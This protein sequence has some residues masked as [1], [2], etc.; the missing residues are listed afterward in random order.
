MKKRLVLIGLLLV[1]ML[2]ILLIGLMNSTT[3]SRW[4]VQAVLPAQV[5]VE[6][7]DGRLLDR[8]TLLGLRYESDSETIAVRRFVFA[9]QPSQLFLGVIKIIDVTANDINISL[10]ETTQAEPSTFDPNA[11][12]PVPMP[13][14]LENLLVTNLT[15]QQD[16]QLQHLEKLHLSAFTEQD[17]LNI[18]ALSVNAKPVELTAQGQMVLGK[19]FPLNLTADWQVATEENGLWQAKTTI[20]GDLKQLT[21]D[22]RL[23]SP[24]KLALNGRLE[25]LQGE[26][27]ISLQGDWQKL[28]WPPT[29]GAPQVSSNQGHI[30]LN[31]LLSDYRISLD[32][33]LIQPYLPKA[34][35]T[36]NGTGSLDAL[37]IETLE[38]ESTA[39]IFQIDGNVSWKDATTFDLKASGQNFNPAI[40]MPELPGSLT[41][42]ARL[43]G[44]LA[45]E[46]LRLDADIKQLAGKLRGY[47][48][49]AN[50]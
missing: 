1:L 21:F 43:K 41:F 38:L 4:L 39:G 34:R 46:T 37:T 19:G 44:Q 23:A 3:V 15:I 29:G 10:T 33:D 31:G 48:V 35:L 32:G 2:P 40:L 7:I 11:D 36:F 47:P 6:S 25:D 13:I 26:L 5:S 28:N 42:N 17:R 16:G 12:L 24:F 27:K 49:S 14:A 8:I 20:N 30:E 45:D 9:W 18:V 50:G 22:S